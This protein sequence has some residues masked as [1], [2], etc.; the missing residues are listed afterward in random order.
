MESAGFNRSFDRELSSATDSAAGAALRVPRPTFPFHSSA[1]WLS[2]VFALDT[3]S[4]AVFRVGLAMLLGFDLAIRASNLTA[5][6]S[7]AG[8][9]PLERIAGTLPIWPHLWHGS[10]TFQALLFWLAAV[11]TIALAMGVATQPVTI[12]CWWLLTSL[13]ARNPLLIHGGDDLLRMLLFWGIFLPLGECWSWDARRLRGTITRRD[14]VSIASAALVLQLCVLY[15]YTGFAKT[16]PV[17]WRDGSAVSYAL[18]LDQLVTRFGQWLLQFPVGLRV[19][20]Y[21]TLLVELCGPV[22]TLIPTRNGWARMLAVGC[23]VTLHVGMALCLHLGNFA[24]AAI[25]AW[26]ALLPRPFWERLRKCRGRDRHAMRDGE[27]TPLSIPRSN[28]PGRIRGAVAALALGFVLFWNVGAIQAAGGR[29]ARLGA[30]LG[31]ALFLAQDWSMFAPRP[32]TDDGWFVAA[33]TL[34]NGRE[35]DLLTNGAPVSWE[36][37]ADVAGRFETD[38]WREYLL[39]IWSLAHA[40]HR[41]DYGRFLIEQWDLSHRPTE[42]VAELHLYYMLEETGNPTPGEP[43]AGIAARRVLLLRWQPAETFVCPDAHP[44]CRANGWRARWLTRAR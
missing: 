41:V 39:K 34:R 27:N 28:L 12:A 31:H 36:K 6:Y 37:P 23:F 8:V 26:F 38:R 2:S 22:L 5:H 42:R 11:G 33:T 19:L 29:I 17:W 25:V 3:R 10:S 20:T 18:Q 7:N 14:E 40:A 4:L 32:R 21:A 44:C 30:A 1:R 13:H 15:W 9:L 35:V 24:F 16:D 43:A